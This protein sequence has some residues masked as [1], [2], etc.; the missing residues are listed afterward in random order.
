MEF[1]AFASAEKLEMKNLFTKDDSIEILGRIDKLGHDS[2][3]EWGKMNVAQMLAHCASFQDIANG[4]S[5]PKRHLLGRLIGWYVKPLFYND[6][7]L[8]R[9]LPTDRSILIV[10]EKDFEAERHAL[11]QRIVEFQSNGPEKCT[12]HPHPFFGNFT[13]EQWGIGSYKHLDHHLRQFGV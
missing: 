9:N 6:K 8:D 1:L 2:Q 5:L 13:P 10:D 12:K 11:K 3:P 7:P 4:N